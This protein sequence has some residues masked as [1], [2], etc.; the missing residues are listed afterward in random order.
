MPIVPGPSWSGRKP[1]ALTRDGQGTSDGIENN[2]TLI[3]NYF[4]NSKIH[5]LD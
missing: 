2:P 1:E 3:I 5:A 4:C